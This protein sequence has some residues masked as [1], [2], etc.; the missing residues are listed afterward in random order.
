MSSSLS[1]RAFF[2]LATAIF[3]VHFLTH[4]PVLRAGSGD[5]ALNS[6]SDAA[7][8]ENGPAAESSIVANGDVPHVSANNGIT[9]TGAEYLLLA[10]EAS[11]RMFSQ[12][13]N[14]ICQER[15]QRFRSK[16]SGENRAIDVVEANVAVEDGE[17]RYSEI[18]QDRRR[19]QTMQQIGGAWSEGEYATFLREARKVLDSNDYITQGYVGKLN[20]VPAVLFPFD[21]EEKASTWDFLVKSRRYMLSFHG[22]L[23]ISQETGEVLRIRRTAHHLDVST[24]ISEVDW[25]VDFSKIEING[26]PLTLPVKAL[27]SVTYFRDE[28]RE[29]NL[30][31]FYNYKRFGSE[32]TVRFAEVGQES[33][34]R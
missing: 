24:G 13:E 15:I 31:S 19:R 29:W 4:P 5:S 27:Y 26:R 12:V 28:T 32:S 6:A 17:E 30:T 23:W 21:I 11:A 16:H 25:T 33:A 2:S 7:R 20:G 22:E 34:I 3:S 10:R 1:N 18:T 14:V 9:T 8:A